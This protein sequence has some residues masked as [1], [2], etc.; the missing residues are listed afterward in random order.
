MFGMNTG[1]TGDTMGKNQLHDEVFSTV[2]ER[3]VDDISL[4]FFYR[5]HTVVL[6]IFSITVALASSFTR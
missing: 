1:D 6:L 3:N 2:N 5:P 4:E